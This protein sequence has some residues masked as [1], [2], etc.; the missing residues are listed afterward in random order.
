M[1]EQP[2]TDH[3]DDVTMRGVDKRFGKCQVLSSVSFS[4]RG[5]SILGLI[6]A[7][8]SG[9]TTLLRLLLGLIRADA[10]RIR[11]YGVPPPVALRQHPV[12]YFS[13]GASVPL[14]V[15]VG[16]WAR[17][18]DSHGPLTGD[19]RR[20]GSLSRGQRQLVGLWSVLG[21]EESR[22]VVLDEPWAG[23]DPRGTE[24][25]SHRLRRCRDRGAIVVVSSHRLDQ[26]ATV[27]DTYGFLHAGQLTMRREDDLG[28][29]VPALQRLHATY[30]ELTTEGSP[31]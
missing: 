17:L 12:A 6:G 3:A 11:L 29:G 23:L 15:R 7:N 5:G 30:C 13:G 10:G 4:A 20:V 9:K 21:Q 2:T 19:R 31:V 14:T 18:F 27:C 22:L 1:S 26:L 24:W 16:R 8:G 25:L 28:A